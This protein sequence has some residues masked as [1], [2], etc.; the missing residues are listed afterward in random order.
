MSEQDDKRELLR[1]KQ[2]IIEESEAITEKVREEKPELHGVEKIDNFFYHYKWHVIVIVF[3]VAVV[4]YLTIMTL[5]KEAADLRVLVISD[6]KEATTDLEYKVNDLEK[7]LEKYCPDFDNNGNVHVDVYYIDMQQNPDSNYYFS[8]Q[9][10]LYGELSSGVAHLFIANKSAIDD[11]IGDETEPMFEN[12]ETLFG[13][14]EN[15]HDML[16]QVKGT[17]LATDAKWENSCPEDFYIAIRANYAG[18]ISDTAQ[19]DECHS[20]AL[21]VFKNILEGNKVNG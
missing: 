3:F 2:G 7:A 11:I 14:S 16:Y 13:G 15:L 21:E 18:L 6:N 12:L 20:R 19:L 4:G 17:Q 10:K 1:L 8:N 5:S 9:A